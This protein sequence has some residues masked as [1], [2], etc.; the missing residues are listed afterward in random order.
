[1]IKI[2]LVLED[3]RALLE[4]KTNL[5]EKQL[6]PVFFY[7]QDEIIFFYKV[8]GYVLY[9]SESIKEFLPETINIEN[10]IRDEFRAI[11][12]HNSLHITRYEIIG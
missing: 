6:H 5:E 7:D 8:I 10:L 2:P 1:M 9:Y 11:E 3:F 12:V 4:N